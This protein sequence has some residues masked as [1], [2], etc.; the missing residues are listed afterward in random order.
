MSWN[1]YPAEK[2]ETDAGACGFPSH[3]WFMGID[4]RISRPELIFEVNVGERR[5]YFWK[6][7]LRK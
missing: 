5:N 3:K 6:Q 7:S 4:Y 1:N 2:A